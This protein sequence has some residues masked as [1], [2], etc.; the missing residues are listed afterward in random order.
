M[1]GG[2]DSGPAIVPGQPEESL[3]VEGHPLRGRRPADAAVEEAPGRAGR[4]PSRDGSRWVRP[5]RAGRRPP[6]PPPRAS[7]GTRSPTRT[8]ATGPSGPSRGPSVPPVRDREWAANPIDALRAGEARG[9]G[10]DAEPAGEQ[11]GAAPPRHLRPDRPAADAR[12]GRT[13][14]SPTPSP[15]AYETLIDRLLASP[16]YG[17]KWG[18][19]WLDLVRYAETNSYER[20]N[21]K[22][23]RLAIPRLRHPVAQRRQAVRPVRPRAARRRRAARPRPRRAHRHRLLPPG[24]LGRRAVRPR[25]GPLRRARR[26]RGH[27]R[28]GLPR[29]DGRLRPLPRPQDRPDPAEGLLPAPGLL[30]QHQPLPQRRPDRRSSRSST[31]GTERAYADRVRELESRRKAAQATIT[32]L[33]EEFR[34]RYVP[35]SGET[36]RETDLDDLRYRFYRDTW[37]RLPDFAALKHEDEGKLPAASSTSPRAPATRPSASSSRAR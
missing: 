17:E 28:P 6:R 1:L 21:P 13:R 7:R 8:A 15:D 18:R 36:V 12:R 19:H 32:G 4:R 37:D 11:G 35:P 24:H 33:E 10:P 22:P 26:H 3:L 34:K 30:P 31:P 20:D 14:S 23:Q 5:G 29:P 27:D 16:R 9:E 2:G 25:A